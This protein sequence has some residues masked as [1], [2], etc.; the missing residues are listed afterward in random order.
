LRDAAA[1]LAELR[2]ELK[3]LREYVAVKDGWA[4]PTL[5]KGRLFA[6]LNEKS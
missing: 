3:N 2:D 1:A 6:Q 4:D 5:Y